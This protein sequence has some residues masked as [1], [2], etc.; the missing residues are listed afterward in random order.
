M[1]LRLRF[2]IIMAIALWLIKISAANEELLI[3]NNAIF[4]RL[5]EIAIS[6][7]EW[8]VITDLDLSPAF[9]IYEDLK[10]IIDSHKNDTFMVN[11]YPM[12]DKNGSSA[13]M[14]R[15]MSKYSQRLHFSKERLDTFIYAIENDEASR[16]KRALADIGGIALKWL[17]GV[18]V[19]SDLEKINM[20]VKNV[21]ET[22]D[23]IARIL[24]Q[25]AT[26]VSASLWQIQASAQLIGELQEGVNKLIDRA[27]SEMRLQESF[28][29]IETGLQW[30]EEFTRRLAGGLTDLENGHLP[31]QIFHPP[32]LNIVLKTIKNQLPDGWKITNSN[33]WKIYTQ[34]HVNVAVI[35]SKLRIFI[36]IP[37]ME[38]KHRHQ[39]YK[40]IKLPRATGNET[41][42]RMII[43]NLPDYL[44]VNEKE[45]TFVEISEN[46]IGDCVKSQKSTCKYYS[47]VMQI[48]TKKTCATAIFQNND[49]IQEEL[50]QR[51]FSNWN[52]IETIDLDNN[53]LVVISPK[54]V[55][56]TVHCPGN[57]NV[58][59]IKVEEIEIIEVKPGCA[60]Q[61]D[62]WTLPA[63]YSEKIEYEMT[64][65]NT[66]SFYRKFYEE[67][68]GHVSKFKKTD[69]NIQGQLLESVKNTISKTGITDQ[70][71]K[72]LKE[73]LHENKFRFLSKN[74]QP[75]LFIGL[76]SILIVLFAIIMVYIRLT[77]R[78]TA[79]EKN[80]F[81]PEN[82]N[83]QPP[84]PRSML[85]RGIKNL[86]I[87]LNVVVDI[88]LYFL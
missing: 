10:K 45:K 84:L 39:L 26:V 71:I 18:A 72:M 5:P 25:Q 73:K 60:T 11:T 70:E 22:Q 57:E 15:K 7:S 86:Y 24:D 2:A 30:L 68:N 4:V 16:Q 21:A 36:I 87:F 85:G 9:G 23:T 33:V 75:S 83:E 13:Y 32:Q 88:L 37:I 50:C 41:L 65:S 52:G 20:Q 56:I 35:D 80:S 63:R 77:Q 38:K 58:Q 64:N 31:A 62:D 43:S 82:P 29:S 49:T 59:N 54:P 61:T 8:T 40:I 51:S 74:P 47:S 79:Y 48:K 55:V 6:D 76:F 12:Y 14:E 69:I 34:S 28:D 53:K 81:D 1:L 66:S 42:H 67:K 78:K 27:E 17:F 44:A 19:D 3:R 46:D